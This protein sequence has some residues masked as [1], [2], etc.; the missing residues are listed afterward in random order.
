MLG[1]C[2]RFREAVDVAFEGE[3]ERESIRSEPSRADEESVGICAAEGLLGMQCEEDCRGN[4]SASI[5][6]GVLE[7]LTSWLL[8]NEWSDC[9]DGDEGGCDVAT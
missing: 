2:A 8:D 1:L 5:S 3:R 9:T 7:P 4:E 6:T